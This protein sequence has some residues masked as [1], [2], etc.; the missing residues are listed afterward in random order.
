[1]NLNE[2]SRLDIDRS[3]FYIIKRGASQYEMATDMS[4]TN[5]LLSRRESK[6]GNR[7]NG[8]LRWLMREVC[9]FHHSTMELSF[10]D[11]I[12]ICWSKCHFSCSVIWEV[13]IIILAGPI[14]DFSRSAVAGVSKGVLNLFGPLKWG[15]GRLGTRQTSFSSFVD[16]NVTFHVLDVEIIIFIICRSK[17]HFSCFGR[18]NHHFCHLGGRNH[19]FGRSHLWLLQ[20]RCCGG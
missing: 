18:R 9:H 20:V 4:S 11:E 3:L 7:Q 13:E 10:F 1:M 6:Q 12:V 2:S 16:R 19:H 14:S 8:D 5:F 17:C 15:W